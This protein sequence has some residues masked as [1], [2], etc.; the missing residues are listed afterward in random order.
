MTKLRKTDYIILAVLLALVI[1]TV[2]L[3]LHGA[4]QS[5]ADTVESQTSS[6]EI[7]YTDFD[8]KRFGIKTGSGFEP[9]VLQTFPNSEYFYFDS[10]SDEIVA[11]QANKMAQS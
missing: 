4:N 6:R 8:G 11:L 10:L 3:V 2:C 1:G 7:S 5:D 9:V